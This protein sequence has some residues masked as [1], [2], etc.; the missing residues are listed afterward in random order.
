M[1]NSQAS[2]RQP[3]STYLCRYSRD[4][5]KILALACQYH[6]CMADFE[7]ATDTWTQQREFHVDVHFELH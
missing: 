5:N 7:V 1:F 3:K 2:E 4:H 6:P